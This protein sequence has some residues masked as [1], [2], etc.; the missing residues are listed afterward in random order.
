MFGE[1]TYLTR[2]NVGLDVSVEGL[3]LEATVQ[4]SPERL[5]LSLMS[6]EIVGC[7]QSLVV[8]AAWG[9]DASVVE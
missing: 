4:D 3:P 7:S 1:L 2:R 5:G 6:C 8:N 9:Y